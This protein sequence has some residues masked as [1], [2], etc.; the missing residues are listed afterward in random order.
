MRIAS[1]NRTTRFCSAI[2]RGALS[3]YHARVRWK[4]HRPRMMAN[5]ETM[6]MVTVVWLLPLGSRQCGRACGAA[7]GG[8]KATTREND[9][10]RGRLR[11]GRRHPGPRRPAVAAAASNRVLPPLIGT[12]TTAGEQ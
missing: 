5:D 11:S 6:A 1:P 3:R 9:R 7:A 12:P 4:R 8:T 2:T 10:R